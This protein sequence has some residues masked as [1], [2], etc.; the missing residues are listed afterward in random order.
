MSNRYPIPAGECRAEIEI[1]KS[2]FIASLAPVFSVNEAKAFIK[3]IKGEFSDAS[4]NVP[5]FV[6]GFGNSVT[7]HC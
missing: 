2:R 7:A 5:A 3:R 1:K 6:V 4:H